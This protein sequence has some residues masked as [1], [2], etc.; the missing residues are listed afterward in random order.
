[1]NVKSSAINYLESTVTTDQRERMDDKLETL[2]FAI[3][4][5]F[6]NMYKAGLISR[7]EPKHGLDPVAGAFEAI[8]Q[9]ASLVSQAC[10]LGMSEGALKRLLLERHGSYKSRET[11]GRE[12][13]EEAIKLIN[14]DG[15]RASEAAR[16]L[17]TSGINLLNQLK[18][19]GYRYNKRIV[20]CQRIK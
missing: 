10:K 17:G 7:P 6:E 20:K 12:I 19:I 14:G 3:K 8:N 15:L 18:K 9:G 13:A 5:K 4:S 16:R 1:M 11:I 2:R